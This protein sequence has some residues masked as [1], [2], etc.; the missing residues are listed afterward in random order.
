MALRLI[1][2]KGDEVLN[3]KCK[4]VKKFNDKL[5]ELL[6]DMYDTMKNADGVG[7][8]APQV[9]II[10]RC[11]V[12]EVDDK[13]IELVNPVIT[14][15][16]GSQI[17]QEGC[18]SIPNV[19]G[20]VERP[21]TVTVSAFDRFGNPFEITGTGLLAVAMCH[22]IDHLEGELFDSKIIECEK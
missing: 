13:K 10:K 9:G 6:D 14:K 1:R 5:G 21:E 2:K 18:L 19:W 17:G 3:T 20:D 15:S 11:V 4:E 8:A 22:E 12:I 7:L 16:E